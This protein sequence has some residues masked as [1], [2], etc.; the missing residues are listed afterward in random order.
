[1]RWTNGPIVVLLL[2][3]RHVEQPNGGID[4]AGDNYVRDKLSLIDRH[5]DGGV[6]GPE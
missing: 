2:S 6:Y 3:L 1:M 4:E 5:N